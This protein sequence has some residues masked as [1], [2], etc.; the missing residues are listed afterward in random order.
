[1]L[2]VF[3]HDRAY[4]RSGDA[5]SSVNEAGWLGS[6]HVCHCCDKLRFLQMDG[7]NTCE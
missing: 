4:R 2:Q 7:T 5:S 1:M 6:C 3:V